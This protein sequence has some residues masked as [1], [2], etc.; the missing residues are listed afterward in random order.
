[1]MIPPPAVI[2]RWRPSSAARTS[3]TRDTAD[4]AA[5]TS[6]RAHGARGV[7]AVQQ[8]PR[9]PSGAVVAERDAVH[10]RDQGDGV[11]GGNALAE[12]ERVRAR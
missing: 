4:T 3:G 6:P 10:E 5:S 7:L 1:M 12:G 8:D 2:A 9:Q 11:V